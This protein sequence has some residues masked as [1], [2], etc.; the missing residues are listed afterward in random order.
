MLTLKLA[1]FFEMRVQRYKYF[2]IR[3]NILQENRIF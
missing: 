3:A 1:S 2:L